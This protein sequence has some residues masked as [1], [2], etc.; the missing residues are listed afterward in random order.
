[1]N[2]VL[3]NPSKNQVGE[4]SPLIVVSSILITLYL[5]ANIMAVK[6]LRIGSVSIFDAGTLTFPFAYM[7]GD[8]LSEIWG[9]KTA[10]KVIILTFVCNLI[11]VLFTF[12]GIYLPY[13]EYME[14]TQNAY[15]TIFGYVP[16][17]VF[18][19]LISF[20]VGELVNAKVLVVMRD[21][22]KDK[23]HLWVRTITSSIAGYVFDTVMFVL[24]A[25]AGTVPARDLWSMIWIQYLA[26]LLI[27]AI[28]G[29]PLAYAAIGYLRRRFTKVN[30]I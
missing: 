2:K 29:T 26:K 10:K 15:K 12:I 5:V 18:A 27:E 30:N 1:M 24:L 16:R 17:I 25:F 11:L 7:L 28:A 21:K 9:Y 13:P 8:V 14:E 22:S 6:I 19:S 23:K 4:F 3:D 20:L